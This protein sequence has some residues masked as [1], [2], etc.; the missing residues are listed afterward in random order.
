MGVEVKGFEDLPEFCVIEILRRCEEEDILNFQAVS[1]W[2][3]SIAR[4]PS[5]WK[6]KLEEQYRMV[7]PHRLASSYAALQKLHRWGMGQEGSW[8]EWEDTGKELEFY[9]ED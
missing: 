6:T 3:C 9:A 5:L 8:D 4:V 2:A 1:S 7:L